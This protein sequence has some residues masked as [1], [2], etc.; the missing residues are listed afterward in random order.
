MRESYQSGDIKGFKINK[1]KPLQFKRNLIEKYIDNY[2]NEYKNKKIKTKRFQKEENK[3]NYFIKK[4][5][6]SQKKN[7]HARLRRNLL[8]Y[9]NIS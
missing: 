3:E 9:I 5:P 6:I 8:Y 2:T 4:N 7:I 1:I